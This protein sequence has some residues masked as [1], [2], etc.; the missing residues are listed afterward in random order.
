MIFIRK[1]G[2]QIAE[3]M[4]RRRKAVQEQNGRSISGTGFA[5]EDFQP[6]HV[7]RA[8]A[9]RITHIPDGTMAGMEAISTCRRMSPG[10]PSSIIVALRI[11]NSASWNAPLLVSP[12]P[13]L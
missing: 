11:E 5:I 12:V 8:I 13:E 9:K 10:T 7:K 4:R 1:H 6:L 3:H 2:N